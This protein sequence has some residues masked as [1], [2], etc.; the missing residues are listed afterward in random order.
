MQVAEP[1][2][3]LTAPTQDGR[4]S[5]LARLTAEVTPD[6]NDNSVRF[7]RSVD[8]GD[9]KT[10]GT[11]CRRSRPTRVSDDVSAART[12]RAGRVPRGAHLRPRQDR[13]RARSARS[14]RSATVDDGDHPLHPDGQ[15]LRPLGP[16]PVRRR[17]RPRRGDADWT[18]AAPFEGTDAYGALHEIGIADDEQQVG[19]IV[20]GRPPAREPRHQGPAQLPGPLLHADL[21]P[22]DL[23][24]GGRRDDLLLSR[25][26]LSRG[27]GGGSRRR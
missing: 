20:H 23:A 10:V 9:W 14:P 18:G 27:S 12:G 4:V 13:R 16:P 7:E 15:R 3:A 17:A 25:R 8:G 5:G 26:R 22:G 1:A 11:R 2:V 6:D 24:Q 21:P 19:F